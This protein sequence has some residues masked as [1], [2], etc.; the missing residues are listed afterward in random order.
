MPHS[1]ASPLLHVRN[2]TDSH[3]QCLMALSVHPGVGKRW[4][5]ANFS[6]PLNLSVLPTQLEGLSRMAS[7]GM[8]KSNS[9]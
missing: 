2:L 1:T 9:A 4:N 5:A 7:G 8:E 6:I 3:C